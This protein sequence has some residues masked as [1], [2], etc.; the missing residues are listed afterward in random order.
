M[1]PAFL[2]FCGLWLAGGCSSRESTV[3]N[4]NNVPAPAPTSVIPRADV[5]RDLEL[6]VRRTNG[7]PFERDRDPQFQV[8]LGNRSKTTSYPVVLSGDG[9]EPGWREPHAWYTIER[10]TSAGVWGVPGTL[11]FGRCGM[12]DED[13]SKDVVTLAPGQEIVLP[14]FRF[15]SVWDLE[16]ATDVRIVAHYAYGDHAKDPAKVPPALHGMPA[17][18][19]SSSPLELAVEEP[20]V[21]EV[22]LKGALPT[23]PDAALAPAV[24]V[25]AFNRSS[26]PVPIAAADQGSSLRLE[27]ETT[28]AS[29]ATERHVLETS[30]SV[31]NAT[32][33]LAAGARRSIVGQAKTLSW[34]SLPK[35]ARPRRVRALLHVWWYRNGV[36]GESDERVARSPWVDVK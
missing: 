1:R 29:G 7:D 19:L 33:R 28:E 5:E 13:W 30:V 36:D 2:L 20:L 23:G 18:T 31:D 25:V 35:A 15:Y 27:V 34:V 24:D 11:P 12:Y 9:S 10:K 21:L 8:I 3:V 14:W 32:D 4:T 6:K 17:Y 16:D 22:T 26:K